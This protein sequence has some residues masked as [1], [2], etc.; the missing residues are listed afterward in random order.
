MNNI[1]QEFD[2]SSRTDKEKV[3]LLEAKCA[4]LKVNLRLERILVK[5]LKKELSLKQMK[6]SNKFQPSIHNNCIEK[7]SFS[8]KNDE[9]I[10]IGGMEEED[11]SIDIVIFGIIFRYWVVQEKVLKK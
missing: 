3:W 9:H 11:G 2:E 10:K 6:Y 5:E 4:E 8:L 1:Y 7:I